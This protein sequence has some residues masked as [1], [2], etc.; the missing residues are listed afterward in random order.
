MSKY[1]WKASL[2]K[3]IAGEKMLLELMPGLIRL[4]GKAADFVDNDG[5]AYE[6]KA[7]QYPMAQTANLFI[8]R[9]S[10][11]DK[12]KIGGPWQAWGRGCKFF[13]YLYAQDRC[14]FVF[15]TAELMKHIEGLEKTGAVKP[16]EIRNARH[17]TVGYK[18]PRESVAHLVKQT[19]R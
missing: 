14:A 13:I 11:I 18:V 5:H 1:G 8:E 4:A 10:D 12:G 15:E 17:T 7:D 19:V 2:A 6:V 9:Y 16:V 3:G